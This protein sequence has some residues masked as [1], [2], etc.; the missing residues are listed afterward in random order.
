VWR[1]NYVHDNNDPNVPQGTGVASAGP[2]GTGMVIAGGRFDTIVNNRFVNNKAWGV[3]TTPYPDSEVPPS[4]I[5]QHCQGGVV[6]TPLTATAFGGTG[7][8]PCY[9]S[10]WGNEIAH[11]TFT[12]NGGFG[13]PTNGD[14]AD[15]SSTPPEDPTAPGNCW[16]DNTDTAGPV[17]QWPQSLSAT[18][19]TCGAPIY[20]DPVEESLLIGEALCDSNFLQQASSSLP[21]CSLPPATPANYPQ[22]TNV[23]MKPLPAHLAT[24]P[25]PCAGVPANPW[26]PSSGGSSN[27]G[28]SRHAGGSTLARTG[29][30]A[31]VP[32][33][34][35]VLL[36]VAGL[37]RRRAHRRP[38]RL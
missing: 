16:H 12:H 21:A 15:I 17:T 6:N 11:N 18:N 32:A 34:A 5:G 10:D 35:V 33:T 28:E 1:N 2:V 22:P 30:T 23:V 26:C 19:G 27:G 20:P 37:L 13:N 7:V 24:M 38:R 31:A 3:L 29:L 8:V 25:N 4:D 36:A 9:F 14:F